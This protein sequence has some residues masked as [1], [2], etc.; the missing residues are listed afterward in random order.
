MFRVSGSELRGQN[1]GLRLFFK[2]NLKLRKYVDRKLETQKRATRINHYDTVF[3]E[4]S[5]LRGKFVPQK[6]SGSFDA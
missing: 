2:I 6:T 4:E 5:D 1:C 3:P